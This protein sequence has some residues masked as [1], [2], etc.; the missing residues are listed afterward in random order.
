M[1][2]VEAAIKEGRCV[3]AVGGS[4]L[5][6]P[7]VLAELN[8]RSALPIVS[9]GSQPAG[10]ATPVDA[11]KLS[12]ALDHPGGVVVLVE[13]DP[14]SDGRGL[15][16][17]E[18]LVKGAKH[19]PRLVIASRSFNPFGLPMGLRLLKYDHEKKRAADFL[20]VL[21]V[22]A[23]PPVAAAAA[24]AAAAPAAKA[25]KAKKDGGARAPL[26]QLVGREDELAALG[27]LLAEDG[28]PIVVTGP[29]G[30][31]RS[32][33]VDAALQATELVRLPDVPLLRGV[34]ADTLL[35]QLAVAAQAGG[36]ARLH[37]ALT[38][39]ERPS[40]L[41]MAQ[42][43]A[44]VLAG[45]AF[46][47]K[48]I[49]FSR[50]EQL[51]DRRDD[52]FRNDG[53]LELV[54]R[55]V[56]T[57]TPAG[58]VIFISER[59][60]AFYREGQ[61]HGLRHLA[62]GGIKGKEL[63]GL[64]EQYGAPEF[65]RDRF[66]PISDRTHGHPIAARSFAIA[67]RQEDDVEE[68]LE[69]PRFLKAGALDDLAPLKRHLKKKVESLDDATRALLGALSTAEIPVGGDVLRALGVKRATR[70][71]LLADGLLEQ[72]PVMG[73]GRMY[74][75]HPLVREHL[76]FREVKDFEVMET[77]ARQLHEACKALKRDGDLPGSI[78]LAYAGNRL[79]VGA[80]RG[81]SRLRLPYPDGDAAL[82]D[83]RAMVRRRKNARLDLA[84]Q[85][86]NE[87][88]KREPHNTELLLLNAE[89]CIAEKAGAEAIS[90][91]FA[92]AAEAAPT[93]EVFH[94]EAN[95]HGNQRRGKAVA[96]LERGIE[97]FPED[98][99]MR[100]R[101]AGFYI[102]QNRLDDAATVLKAAQELEPMMP[103]TYGMLGEI[104]TL[105]GPDRWDDAVACIEE[106]LRLAPEHP[107]HLCRKAALL[108]RQAAA[109]ADAA[110]ALLEEAETLATTALGVDKGDSRVQVLVATLILDR[111]GDAEKARWLLQQALKQKETPEALLQ[112][113]RVLVVQGHLDEAERVLDK[114][115]KKAPSAFEAFEVKGELELGRG[116]VFGALE[117]YKS[118]RER[119]P[120]AAPERARHERRMAELGALIESG[121][122]TEMLK[123][124]AANAGEAA[125]AATGGED[126]PRRDAG[127]TTKLRK[128]AEGEGDLAER[129]G[130]IASKLGEAVSEAATGL[131][132][133]AAEA[134]EELAHVAG[135]I[136]EEISETAAEAVRG[137]EASVDE[138][139]SDAT[140]ESE[141]GAEE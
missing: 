24:A 136:V 28:G 69:Q 60:P 27:A 125:P 84:R 41:A 91:A 31:G 61:A 112:R 98:A 68:L 67:A 14:A 122:A 43:V 2:R 48:A 137:L 22:P 82:D 83:L 19:K 38:G 107:M 90:A 46:T 45:E 79:L 21:S 63:H 139:E 72:T 52:S 96:A 39:K 76:T 18:S 8:R 23:G 116:N 104:Y 93:P 57:S 92:R 94:A 97:A 100:R 37:E 5:K 49:V 103:D 71:Q 87:T 118:A 130:A 133:V 74:S 110:P 7:A 20:G 99:R 135:D 65:P 62:L 13:P 117:A 124:A 44:E 1:N 101:L 85:R 35:A 140:A 32:W 95:W 115:I 26:P 70:I 89:L 108:R 78:S 12:A 53:R 141:A 80:R 6:T 132:G 109:D 42:L 81:R 58:R 50:L 16:A 121:A 25:N 138:A 86:V 64:F 51:L 34:G 105:L 102:A 73:E 126:G 11:G 59:A 29:S 10:P 129:A 9:L 66:G 3:L 88:M 55:A 33:L 40:P 123:A 56:L 30:V 47:G 77:V 128:K 127:T 4:A 75:V 113:A 15:G 120:K 114:A 131:A 134:A 17:L 36:D 111:G 119:S 106:A 54:L